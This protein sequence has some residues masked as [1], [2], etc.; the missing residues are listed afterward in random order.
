MGSGTL[1]LADKTAPPGV[2]AISSCQQQHP[3]GNR[4]LEESIS[5]LSHG[6]AHCRRR[7]CDCVAAQV[8]HVCAQQLPRASKKEALLLPMPLN[9]AMSCTE[10]SLYWTHMTRTQSNAADGSQLPAW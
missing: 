2:Q 6:L 4:R 7:P 9:A 1:A 5:Y 10:L 3:F 8:N